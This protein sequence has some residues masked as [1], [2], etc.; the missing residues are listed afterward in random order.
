M[1]N[2][3]SSSWVA[4]TL[5]ETGFTSCKDDADAWI[6]PA[7]KSNGFKYYEYRISHVDDCLVVSQNPQITIESLQNCTMPPIWPVESIL[8]WYR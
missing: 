2:L 8:M 3:F 5:T 6:Q 1:P 7:Q 4:T